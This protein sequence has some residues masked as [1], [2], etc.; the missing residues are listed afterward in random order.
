ML[1]FPKF[2]NQ[3]KTIVQST[4]DLSAEARLKLK[5]K[6]RCAFNTQLMIRPK[7]PW[8]LPKS[9]FAKY[10]YDT[11]LVIGKCFD[12]DWRCSTL[13]KMLKDPHEKELII[14]FLRPKYGLIRETYKHLACV[15]PAGNMPS[16][17][18]NILTEIML[19]CNDFVDYK[20]IRLSDVD[21]AFIATNAIGAR[22]FPFK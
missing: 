6:P 1:A 19:K 16:L 4:F 9:F 22:N 2:V 12:W 17:G 8:S 13:D 14:K 18:M 10:K 15:A 7:S 20:Y 21:L 5:A 3:T 11:D